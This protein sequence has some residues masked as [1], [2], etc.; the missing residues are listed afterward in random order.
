MWKGFN[1]ISTDLYKINNLPNIEISNALIDRYCDYCH[2]DPWNENVKDEAKWY[3][4]TYYKNEFKIKKLVEK[5]HP[6][7]KITN[8]MIDNILIT[9]KTKI[10]RY[11]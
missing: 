2:E 8:S 10:D 5:H 11:I 3:L 7:W 1:M 9:F 4:K 6:N